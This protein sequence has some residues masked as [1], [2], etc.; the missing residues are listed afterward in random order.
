MYNQNMNIDSFES[1]Q[2][3][4]KSKKLLKKY[5]IDKIDVFGSFARGE[6]AMDIDIY[7]DV[8]TYE[9]KNLL[10]FK[11]ELEKLSNKEIDLVL[12]KYANP[13][14]LHRAQKDMRYVTE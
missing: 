14:I 8:E 11:K 6:A 2:K 1:F 13:I 4:I 9:I 7:L 5:G 12:K 3:A 10:K